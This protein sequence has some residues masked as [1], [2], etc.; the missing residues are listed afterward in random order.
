MKSGHKELHQFFGDRDNSAGILQEIK[1][2]YIL[3]KFTFSLN[4]NVNISLEI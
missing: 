1:M 2:Q 3:K 4:K